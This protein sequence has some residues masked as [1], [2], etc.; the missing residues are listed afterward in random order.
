MITY[1][2]PTNVS[3]EG[4]LQEYAMV[5]QEEL[6]GLSWM[7]FKEV[8]TQRVIWDEMDR[9]RGATAVHNMDADPKIGSRPGSKRHEYTPIPHKETDLLKESDILMPATLG[10]LGGV[11]D[12]SAEVGRITKARA[13][14]NFIRAEVE[15]WMALKGLLVY[16]NAE[17][18][19]AIHETFPIQT[20]DVEVDF[21]DL[22]NAKPLHE[23]NVVTRRF[24]FTGA[25]AAGAE[26]AMNSTT[27][28]WI[29]ENRNDNDLKRFQNS[30]YL[31]LAYSVEEV[32]KILTARK[33]PTIIV[34]DEGWVDDDD[35]E[36]LFLADG[37]IVIKGKR[38]AGQTVGDTAMTP[39]THRVK[40]GQPAPGMFSIIE[41]NG[42]PNPGAIT[43]QAIGSS[44]N[45]KIEITGGYYGG[46]RLRYPRSIIKVNAKVT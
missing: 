27:A 20:Y 10:T 29:L 25:R 15:A 22:D 39:T 1:R 43:V 3:V 42:Q 35:E 2:F 41:V 23:L 44:K 7:P 40:N 8:E 21:D 12:L 4:V 14:K 37:E 19:I 46:P 38:P 30:N 13:D 17:E 6:L 28:A 32:N 26:M 31:T 9:D 34:Y 5:Q 24:R 18:G 33:Q 11:I 16:T 45:P 36:Q